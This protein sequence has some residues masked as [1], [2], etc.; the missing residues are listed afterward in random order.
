M[1][2]DASLQPELPRYT[3]EEVVSHNTPDSLWVVL[4][5]NVYDVTAFSEEVCAAVSQAGRHGL[6]PALPWCIA[7]ARNAGDR[8]E[9]ACEIGC[10]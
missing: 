8:G 4:D 3:W 9:M 6:Q 5:G 2:T 7:R 10:I 1:A